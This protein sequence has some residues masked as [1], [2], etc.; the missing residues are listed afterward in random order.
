MHRY[1]LWLDV[2]NYNTEK[3]GLLDIRRAPFPHFPVSTSSAHVTLTIFLTFSSLLIHTFRL[4][5]SL[6]KFSTFNLVN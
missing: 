5:I 2:S 3:I 4:G 6:G 1:N